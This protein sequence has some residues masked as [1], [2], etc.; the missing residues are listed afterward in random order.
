MGAPAFNG[1]GTQSTQQQVYY[2]TDKGQYYTNNSLSENNLLAKIIGLPVGAQ[3]RNYLGNP[4]SSTFANRFTPKNIP[5]QYPEM[6]MLFP[7]LN[8]GLLQGVVSSVQ[9]E[10]AMYGAG[11]F[12]APQTTSQSKG[13]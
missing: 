4:Y 8:T 5:A 13:K 1:Q 2:D 3:E 10:G 6:N 12:L 9:P 7:A 11:R